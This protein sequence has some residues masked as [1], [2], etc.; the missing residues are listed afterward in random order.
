M[1]SQA[2]LRPFVRIQVSL[3]KRQRIDDDLRVQ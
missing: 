3:V 1:D 2:S